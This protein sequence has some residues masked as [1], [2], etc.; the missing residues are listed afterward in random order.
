MRF[1]PRRRRSVEFICNWK[2]G[3]VLSVLLGTCLWFFIPLDFFLRKLHSHSSWNEKLEILDE[4]NRVI[5]VKTALIAHYDGL[6]TRGVMTFL[7][8]SEKDGIKKVLLQ[9]RA[10]NKVI[11]PGLWS[12]AEEHLLVGESYE[13]GALRAVQEELGFDAT[14]NNFVLEQILETHLQCNIVATVKGPLYDFEFIE[15]WRGTLDINTRFNIEELEV[16]STKWVTVA[17]LN[18]MIQEEP[19]TITPWLLKEWEL[20]GSQAISVCD[21]SF[22]LPLSLDDSK[23][24]PKKC[25]PPSRKEQF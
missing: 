16:G 9:K 18:K 2:L 8:A 22:K 6:Y 17:V 14:R 5:A 12:L 4:N 1:S 15:L 23:I 7:C 24:V 3:L 13:D 19:E 11:Y 25:S 20:I 10:L 21:E